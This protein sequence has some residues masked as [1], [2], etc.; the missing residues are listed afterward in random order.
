MLDKQKEL[1]MQTSSLGDEIASIQSKQSLK[2]CAQS[3]DFQLIQIY[4]EKKFD[5]QVLF[6]SFVNYL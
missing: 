3:Y 6:I 1:R 5:V 4:F 2:V